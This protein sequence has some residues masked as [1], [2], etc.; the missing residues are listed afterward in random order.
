MISRLLLVRQYPPRILRV[1][2]VLPDLLA[3]VCSGAIEQMGAK[4][5]S[6]MVQFWQSSHL[7]HPTHTLSYRAVPEGSWRQRAPEEH[8]GIIY[9]TEVID[10]FLSRQQNTTFG[11]Q[12]EILVHKHAAGYSQQVIDQALHI[13]RHS[14]GWSWHVEKIHSPVFGFDCTLYVFRFII[15]IFES[16]VRALNDDVRDYSDGYTCICLYHGD[17]NAK[18]LHTSLVVKNSPSPQKSPFLSKEESDI[19]TDPTAAI[20]RPL[21]DAMLEMKE[22]LRRDVLPTSRNAPPMSGLKGVGDQAMVKLGLHTL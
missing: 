8:G 14:L 9:A 3:V 11:T 21:L 15:L 17:E 18:A 16:K 2:R 10:L 12:H 4:G 20:A 13:L 6:P 5:I 22:Q 7:G 1:S 19:S